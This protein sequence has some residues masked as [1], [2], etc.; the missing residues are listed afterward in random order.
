VP[1]HARTSVIAAVR[2]GDLGRRP[3]AVDEGAARPVGG[4]EPR[5]DGDPVDLTAHAPFEPVAI[6]AEE[7]E[8]QTRGAGVDDED[9]V[10]QAAAT[11]VVL[12]RA[13]A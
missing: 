9:R 3:G 5:P 12:R 11:A 4:A 6:E 1:S 13:S 2:V 8:L 10:H 7:L